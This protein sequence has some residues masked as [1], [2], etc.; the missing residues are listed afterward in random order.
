MPPLL[1]TLSSCFLPLCVHHPSS[2]IATSQLIAYIHSSFC[3]A[4]YCY[5]CYSVVLLAIAFSQNPRWALASGAVNYPCGVKLYF[6]VVQCF[7]S[8]LL[9][10]YTLWYFVLRLLFILS[11]GCLS[12]NED[13]RGLVT[14]S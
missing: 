1:F 2:A 11:A 5:D 8:V 10:L 12:H 6:Y 13:S 14:G 9:T 3:L 4:L 7:L